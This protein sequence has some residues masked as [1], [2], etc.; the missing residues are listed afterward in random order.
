[1]ENVT[2]TTVNIITETFRR[3]LISKFAAATT[4]RELDAMA[5]RFLKP[6]L[7]LY[8]EVQTSAEEKGFR[9]H[10][11]EIEVLRDCLN[12]CKG[13]FEPV[14]TAKLIRKTARERALD[15]AKAQ[16]TPKKPVVVRKQPL[17][18]HP[19]KMIRLIIAGGRDYELTTEDQIYLESLIP[20]I[21]CVVS[22][23]ARG[24]DKAGERFAK[25]FGLPLQV[26]PA[27]WDKYGKSAGYRR[28]EQMAEFADA[29]I[30]FPG[31][32]GSHHMHEIAVRKGLEIIPTPALLRSCDEYEVVRELH[33]EAELD[34]EARFEEAWEKHQE[35]MLS[36]FGLHDDMP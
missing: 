33:A 11:P 7:D 12:E 4:Q 36:G 15:N 1:M 25:H 32:K 8:E 22:G 6:L 28:N 21:T 29:A 14:V 34:R 26:F 3:Q 13:M 5:S 19:R 31:G 18:P 17:K 27:E 20:R 30:V 2:T 9:V 35:D 10:D 23:G 16:E 24:A